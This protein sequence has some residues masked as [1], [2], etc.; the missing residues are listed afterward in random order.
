[1]GAMKQH[2]R[3]NV[4]SMRVSDE[5]KEMLIQIMR[6]TRKSLSDIMREALH[7]LNPDMDYYS[8]ESDRIIFS[9]KSS[10]VTGPA[11]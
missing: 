10:R 11:T 4:V 7:R 9:G 1:M 8:K 6:T 2:P 3:Y 5:E